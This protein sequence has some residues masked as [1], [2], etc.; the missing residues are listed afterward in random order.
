MWYYKGAI[1]VHKAKIEVIECLPPPTCVKGV[2]GFLGHAGFYQRFIRNFSKIA[3][4]L[5][6]LLA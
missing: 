2:Q 4:P 5:T 1:E 6:L 3:R